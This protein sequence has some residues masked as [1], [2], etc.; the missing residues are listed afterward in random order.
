VGASV[1][2]VSCPTTT[3][4]VAVDDQGG[5][6]QWAGGRVTRTDVD[7]GRHLTSISCPSTSL[8]VAVDQTGRVVI[9]TPARQG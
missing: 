4:C 5:V 9:G 2:G 1:T 7:A 3:F 6:L 8:C